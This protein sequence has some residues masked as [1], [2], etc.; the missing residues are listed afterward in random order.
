MPGG[1]DTPGPCR[2][3][4]GSGSVAQPSASRRGRGP[5][6][7]RGR[8]QP[9]VAA[10]ASR[11][12]ATAQRS[13]SRWPQST[14][15]SS[16]RRCSASSSTSASTPASR[17]REAG[18]HR[19]LE[20][21]R[22]RGPLGERGRAP[23]AGAD[24]R[25]PLRQPSARRPLGLEQRPQREQVVGQRLERRAA[26]RT[27]SR[28]ATAPTRARP[29]LGMPP[30]DQVAEAAQLVLLRR[31]GSA[32][33]AAADRCA[34][35]HR[36]PRPDRRVRVHAERSERVAAALEQP[37]R[38]QQRGGSESAR[39]TPAAASSR[40]WLDAAAPRSTCRLLGLAP[41]PRRPGR[42]ASAS[43]RTSERPSPSASSLVSG[44]S[45]IPS[46]GA[47][48]TRHRPAVVQRPLE[49]RVRGLEPRRVELEL[50]AL[51]EHA[52]RGTPAAPHR[53]A[54]AAP[55]G[56]RG[57]PRS[58]RY[59]ATPSN[60]ASARAAGAYVGSADEQP[61]PLADEVAGQRPV[62]VQRRRRAARRR[63][64]TS[65]GISAPLAVSA[66]QLRGGVG[67]E[68]LERRAGSRCARR[69]VSLTRAILH[70]ERRLHARVGA[71][72]RSGGRRS[73]RR[74]RPSLRL[75][76]EPRVEDLLELRRAR[77]GA[78]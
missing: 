40:S 49:L 33:A 58:R 30:R 55:A 44:S 12:S 16:A 5:S 72:S 4:V 27:P 23:R 75:A 2:G 53:R 46:S 9:T 10:S 68:R 14:S 64:I 34:E 57:S 13:W 29:P 56:I 22:V 70:G 74:G 42:P 51:G 35:R 19:A 47:I 71:R 36:A 28:T 69:A 25:E 63:S 11:S 59:S 15:R 41:R 52:T 26:A 32:S 43:P 21:D 24:H 31:R 45:A 20:R 73:R 7:D 8:A 39:A 48:T 78:G 62:A 50:A 17:R 67:R 65:N 54:R 18:D 77:S 76:G 61:E 3:R 60:A 38:R 6:S 37:Q 1:Q 66:A